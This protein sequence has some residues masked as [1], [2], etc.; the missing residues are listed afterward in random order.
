M[1]QLPRTRYSQEFREQS[2]KFFKESGLTL[3]E[4]AKGLSLPKGTLK[5]WVYAD[6]QGELT[7]V[8]KKQSSLT[9]LELELSRIKRELAEVKMERDFIKKCAAYFARESR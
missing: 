7:T 8:G 9:E 3:V 1:E 4:A 6:W 5:N 2:V